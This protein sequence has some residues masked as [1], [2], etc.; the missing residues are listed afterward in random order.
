ME[1]SKEH[2]EFVKAHE[3]II[4]HLQRY[5]SQIKRLLEVCDY[6]EADLL[7]GH[8]SQNQF[9]KA[10]EAKIRAYS[11]CINTIIQKEKLL[12][13]HNSGFEIEVIHEK[14]EIRSTRSGYDISRLCLE[15]QVEL[16]ELMKKAKKSSNEIA[17]IQ[18]NK[19]EEII[20]E[21]A[22][23][24]VC[25]VPNITYM[26]QEQLPETPSAFSI[27]SNDPTIR[28]RESLERLAAKRFKEA[29]ASLTEDE[30]R[31]IN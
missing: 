13:F 29:G 18:F 1:L 10:R 12:Q 27:T 2:N 8:V 30:K 7:S 26:K 3:V 24:E 22:E 31:L 4:I 9:F 11:D 20:I 21:D 28:L 6:T 5:N 15:E 25:E 17:A 23:Y 14:V 16:Y 19:V